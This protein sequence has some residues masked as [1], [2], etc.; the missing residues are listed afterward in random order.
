M[1]FATLAGIRMAAW[2]TVRC[3]VRTERMLVPWLAGVSCVIAH[4]FAIVAAAVPE[5]RR[6]LR[7]GSGQPG[8]RGL[9]HIC[10]GA[11]DAARCKIGRR[12]RL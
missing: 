1:Q 11:G 10:T 7:Q 9:L 3:G 8:Q 6:Q 5:P 12:L 2:I 4:L